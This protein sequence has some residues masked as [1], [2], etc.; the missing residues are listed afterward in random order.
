MKN[1]LT[2]L[3]TG[4]SQGVPVIGCDC[5]VCRSADPRDQ[6]LRTAALVHYEGVELVIDAGPDFRQQMLRAG[7]IAPDAILLTHQHKDHTA[8][9]D[10][11]RAFNYTPRDGYKEVHPCP[12]YCEERVQA[13]LRQE[14]SYAFAEEKYPGIPVFDLHTITEVPFT[15]KGV[16]IIPIRV[17]HYRL[18][19]LG[20]R[21]GRL[22]YITDANRIEEA[23]MEKL[24]GVEILIL[25]TIRF[26]PHISHFSV[27]E[28][29]ALAERV[30]ARATW[31]T[32][33]SHQLPPHAA[34]CG[35]LPPHVQPAYDGLTLEF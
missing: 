21:F 12:V 20:F 32:H 2:F 27:P 29:I 17:M 10:D 11:V 16:E 24:R 14:F 19:V 34:L 9:L 13:A 35:Q 23:E 30:G 8:G 25:N 4:T 15:V 6:R 31:L 28:A 5:P 1:T 3:G 18:P 7:V 22:A 26:T 33:L